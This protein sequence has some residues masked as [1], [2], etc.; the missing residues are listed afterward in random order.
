MVY[1]DQQKYTHSGTDGPGSCT[2]SVGRILAYKKPTQVYTA[3][4]AGVPDYQRTSRPRLSRY[5]CNAQ[6]MVGLA[7]NPWLTAH[8]AF[9]DALCCKQTAVKEANCRGYSAFNSAAMPQHW[10][11]KR[12]FKTGCN[13]LNWNGNTP[14]ITLLHT[15]LQTSSGP[16][17]TPI[18]KAFSYLRYIQSFI[19]W[20]GHRPWP[21]ARLC[22]RRIYVIKRIVT[23]KIRNHFRRCWLRVRAFPQTLS[24]AIEY[25]KYHS[26]NAA[27]SLSAR[28]QTQSNHRILSQIN[29]KQFSKEHL[30]ST[31]ADRDSFQHVKKKSWLCPMCSKS[32]QSGSRNSS[33]DTYAQ[34]DDSQTHDLC[35]IQS[36]S[37][38]N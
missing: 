3:T 34:P 38:Y 19:S 26:N 32:P 12:P 24:R 22:R 4:I 31:L 10:A 27:W 7:S 9:Y 16:L 15:P 33:A 36:N 17:Q 35:F 25:K 37:L 21:K 20:N 18:S 8:S 1:E 2:T 23:A 6:R 29:A 28:W 13:R 11:A 14:R 30:W 5:P